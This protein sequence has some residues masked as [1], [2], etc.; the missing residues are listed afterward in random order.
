LKTPFRRP[1]W[2]DVLARHFI[3]PLKRLRRA[4]LVCLA[5]ADFRDTDRIWK[6]ICGAAGASRLQ[7]RRED[8][9]ARLL[10][11]SGGCAPCAGGEGAE[12]ITKVLLLAPDVFLRL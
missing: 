1:L 5:S 3:S 11:V 4:G 7:L 8:A 12:N 9:A 6:G 10:A 2:R